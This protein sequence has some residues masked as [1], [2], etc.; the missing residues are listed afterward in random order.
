MKYSIILLLVLLSLSLSAQQAGQNALQELYQDILHPSDA[1]MNG[2]EYKY[3]FQP[4]FSSP[5]I[6]KDPLPTASLLIR[7]KQYQNVMLF[8]D[9]YMDQLVYYNYNTL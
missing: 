1:L 8:Y 7:E 6:P 9:T 3:Y 4:R 2:R 5:L